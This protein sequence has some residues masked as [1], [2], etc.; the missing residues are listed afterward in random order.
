MDETTIEPVVEKKKGG[1]PML[2]FDL[3]KAQEMKAEGLG[4]NKIAL[5]LGCSAT[6]VRKKVLA[7]TK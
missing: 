4:W 1:R 5:A 2:P 3:A 7:S 6:T